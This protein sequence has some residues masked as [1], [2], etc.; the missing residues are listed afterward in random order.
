M[1]EARMPQKS[2]PKVNK[3]DERFW[4]A[5]ANC[6]LGRLAWR[7]AIFT[8]SRRCANCVAKPMAIKLR[9]PSVLWLQ[10]SVGSTMAAI[11]VRRRRWSWKGESN[12]RSQNAPEKYSQS[13]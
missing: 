11:S 5:A 10:E 9:K 13:Q 2:L 12:G 7:A 8:S 4:Q 6:R 3:V 1:A